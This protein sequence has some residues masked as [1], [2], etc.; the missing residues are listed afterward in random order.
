MEDDQSSWK[1]YFSGKTKQKKA[2]D[3]FEGFGC[4]GEDIND[5]NDPRPRIYLG[6]FGVILAAGLLES[7][8]ISR[9][10][11]NK[12]KDLQVVEQA[13]A[14]IPEGAPVDI[15]TKIQI[16]SLE[17]EQLK[18][19]LELKKVRDASNVTSAKPN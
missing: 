13:A 19:E 9:S 2:R 14:P 3:D 6:I 8:L 16:M 7:F 10:K 4:C 11:K 1:D 18:L 17:I 15:E 12:D 5:F